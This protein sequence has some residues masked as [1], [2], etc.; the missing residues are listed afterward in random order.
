[1]LVNLS[2]R[3]VSASIIRT[4]L[5]RVF[6]HYETNYFTTPL[7]VRRGFLAVSSLNVNK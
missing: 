7:R 6:S 4:P 3:P 1:M 2:L 5:L